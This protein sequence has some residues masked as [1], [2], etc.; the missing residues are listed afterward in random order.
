MRIGLL[1]YHFSDNFGAVL[2]AYALRTWLTQQGYI[3]SFV[4]YHP[5]Y[6]EAGGDFQRIFHFGSLKKNLKVA[7]LKFSHTKR[8]IFGNT[9]QAKKFEDFRTNALGLSGPKIESV[10]GLNNIKNYDFLIAGSDQIWNPS[11]HL[12]LDPAYFLSFPTASSVKKI[13]YAASFGKDELEEVHYPA[14]KE[15]LSGLTAIS[16]REES[17]VSIVKTVSGRSAACVPD[18]TFLLDSYSELIAQSQ[19][20]SKDHI[21]CYALRTGEG[22]RDVCEYYS[23][24]LAVPIFSPYNVHRRWKEIGQTVYPGPA[25]WLKLLVESKYVVTNSFHATVF[26]VLYHKPFIVV[27][28]PGSRQ[29]LNARAKNL[30]KK[31]GLQ[32]R[33]VESNDIEMAKKRFLEPINWTAVDEKRSLLKDQGVNFLKSQLQ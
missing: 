21:F 18:P 5:S 29:G 30:L 8:H 24:Q 31:L 15:L 26:A 10:T 27:G 33:F 4:N 13:S 9:S 25:D 14:A 19:E 16:V 2:Q 12:G 3:A 11:G 32:D 17:G 28:L 6:V 22:I 1:T 7:Y 20:Q 23:D